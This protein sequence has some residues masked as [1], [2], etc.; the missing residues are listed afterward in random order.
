METAGVP[1]WDLPPLAIGRQTA[2]CSGALLFELSGIGGFFIFLPAEANLA[3]VRT[4]EGQVTAFKRSKRNSA[5]SSAIE[6]LR[7]A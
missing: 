4:A 5:C 3:L 2:A 6:D 1:C 7:A